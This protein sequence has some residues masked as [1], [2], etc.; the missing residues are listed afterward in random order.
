MKEMGQAIQKTEKHQDMHLAHLFP[1][2]ASSINKNLKIVQE[3]G[4]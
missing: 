3:Q 4:N 2:S 1:C